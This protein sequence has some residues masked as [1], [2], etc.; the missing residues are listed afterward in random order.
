MTCSQRTPKSRLRAQSR[1]SNDS[2]DARIAR[3]VSN[4][5][6]VMTCRSQNR[7]PH[8]AGMA[9]VLDNAR[10]R[11]LHR[12]NSTS[13]RRHS[14]S[15]SVVTVTLVPLP[16]YNRSPVPISSSCPKD[17]IDSIVPARVM[18]VAG[19]VNFLQ[20]GRI[21]APSASAAQMV[22]MYH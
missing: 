21:Y 12:G 1:R 15:F 9:G 4:P 14:I 8:R 20:T 3:I 10:H 16:R 5:L 11:R 7:T 22:G 13:R 2:P 19:I 17:R 18:V 6:D